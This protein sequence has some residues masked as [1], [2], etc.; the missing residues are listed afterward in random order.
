MFFGLSLPAL[1]PNCLLGEFPGRRELKSLPQEGSAKRARHLASL[2]CWKNTSGTLL[3]T[4]TKLFEVITSFT[5]GYYNS[6]IQW[7]VQVY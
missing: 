4:E 7:L 6:D 1:C 5:V 2:F 3:S